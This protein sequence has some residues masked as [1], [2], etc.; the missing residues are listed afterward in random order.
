MILPGK[1]IASGRHMNEPTPETDFVPLPES[2]ALSDFEFSLA[3]LMFGFQRWV[4]TCMEASGVRGI[5]AMDILTLHAV[6]RRA[7]LSR[8]PEICMM[9]NITD[10]HLIAY[11]LKKLVAA[12]LVKVEQHGRER[13][14]ETTTEGDKICLGYHKVREQALVPNLSWLAERD[15]KIDRLTSLQRMMSA[16]YDQASR[17][18]MAEYQHTGKAPPLRTKK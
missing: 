15:L 17:T 11:S 10:T 4:E 5:A 9:M 6:N 16:I 2:V 13:L 1:Q 18:A 8:I 7:R 14:Y 3:I 12:E